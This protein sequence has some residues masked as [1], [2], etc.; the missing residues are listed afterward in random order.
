MT[1][2]EFKE[3][4][5]VELR[6]TFREGVNPEEWASHIGFAVGYDGE[7][8]KIFYLSDDASDRQKFTHYLYGEIL[9]KTGL[10]MDWDIQ[11]WYS[12]GGSDWVLYPGE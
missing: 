8:Q 9:H 5:K 10:R 1:E 2:L 4:I 7:G 6:K 12:D 11:S 3:G